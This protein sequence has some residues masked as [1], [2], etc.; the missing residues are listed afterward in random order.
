MKLW[1]LSPIVLVRELLANAAMQIP[2]VRNRRLAGQRTSHS[3]LHVEAEKLAAE[4]DFFVDS[5][6]SVSGKVIVEIGPGDAL[7]LAPLFLSAGAARYVG[8]DRFRG[9]VWGR[10]A[11][12]LYDELERQRGPFVAAWRDRVELVDVAIEEAPPQLPSADVIV[13]F[14][15]VEHLTDL[16]SATRNMAA[17]LKADGLMIHRIDYGPHGVWLSTTDPLSFLQ[18]P[19]WLWS[20]IGS[21]RGYPNRARHSQVVRLFEETGLLVAGRVTRSCGNDALDAEVACASAIAPRLGRRFEIAPTATPGP[22]T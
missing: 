12:A 8:I 15:V 14:D 18:V 2:L 1:G 5:I 17:I 20:A 13:S 6:G 9:N 22:A 19:G 7:G 11:S 16:A 10:R 21:N 4:F 3:S